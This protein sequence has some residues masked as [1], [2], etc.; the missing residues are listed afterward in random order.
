MSEISNERQGKIFESRILE[1]LKLFPAFLSSYLVAYSPRYDFMKINIYLRQQNR[2]VLKRP[3]ISP[4][5][6]TGISHAT[7]FIDDECALTILI[8][9]IEYYN[10]NMQPSTRR[11]C[12]VILQTKLRFWGLK[13]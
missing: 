12:I 8:D 1:T 4:Q 5:G 6:Q 2:S 13:M 3:G 10:R 11:S 7:F 9:K